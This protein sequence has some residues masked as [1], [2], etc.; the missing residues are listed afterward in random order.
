MIFK[1]KKVFLPLIGI[2]SSSLIMLTACVPVIF[3]Y[4]YEL[5][6]D[7]K[8]V[9]MYQDCNNSLTLA[10]WNKDQNGNWLLKNL[11]K[12]TPH[13]IRGNDYKYLESALLKAIAPKQMIVYHGVE[14]METEFYEQLKPYIQQTNSGL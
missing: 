6:T 9:K 3:S 11:D 10:N 1:K 2:I 7:L 14:Y 5:P 12:K 4:T 8:L 13:E